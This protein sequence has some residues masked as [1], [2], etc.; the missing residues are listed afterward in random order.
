MLLVRS[1]H[2][3]RVRVLRKETTGHRDVAH[4]AKSDHDP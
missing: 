2:T 3:M 1:H 4:S